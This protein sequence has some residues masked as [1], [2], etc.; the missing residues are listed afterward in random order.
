MSENQLIEVVK[1][2]PYSHLVSPKSTFSQIYLWFYTF[3][4]D[5]KVLS[6]I[7][8]FSFFHLAQTFPISLLPTPQLFKIWKDPTFA[9]TKIFQC[10]GPWLLSHQWFPDLEHGYYFLTFFSFTCPFFSHHSTICRL[11]L[12]WEPATFRT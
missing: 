9:W 2:L 10:W 1:T 5:M 7:F 3:C 4:D 11:G 6:L 8:I 12:I